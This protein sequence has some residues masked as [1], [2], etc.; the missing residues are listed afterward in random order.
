[1]KNALSAAEIWQRK[2]LRRFCEA[3]SILR[4]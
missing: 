1:L 4:F 3:E 2:A